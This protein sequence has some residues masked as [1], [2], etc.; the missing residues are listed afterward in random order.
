M[1]WEAA[2]KRAKRLVAR[3]SSLSW[4]WADLLVELL[5]SVDDI[6]PGLQ[7]IA[8]ESGYD[9]S[10]RTLSVRYYVGL[11]WPPDRRVKAS[12][13]T[14]QVLMAHP[15]RFEIIK[16]GMSG[17]EA[18]EIIGKGVLARLNGRGLNERTI[19]EAIENMAASY[20]FAKLAM[21][22]LE[23]YGPDAPSRAEAEMIRK[24][25]EL[26]VQYG[27]ELL[28]FHGRRSTINTGGGARYANAD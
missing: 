9:G 18:N 13:K 16:D 20:R 3:E 6:E 23:A 5:G 22:T 25:G 15:D 21:R 27:E 1:E 17:R 26:I 7:R 11:A 4:E 12:F 2:L 8:T 19:T 14:H 28:L 24:R 10:W